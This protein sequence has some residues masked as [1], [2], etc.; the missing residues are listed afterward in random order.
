MRIWVHKAL[1]TVVFVILI[2]MSI[3]AKAADKIP[4]GMPC[5]GEWRDNNCYS[6]SVCGAGPSINNRPMRWCFDQNTNCPRPNSN[7]IMYGNSYTF[8][9]KSWICSRSAKSTVYSGDQGRAEKWDRWNDQF[10]DQAAELVF[11]YLKK[12]DRLSEVQ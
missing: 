4:N 1:S 3:Q 9:G 10:N 8:D 11:K 2:A 12:V 5:F 7:G 6:D